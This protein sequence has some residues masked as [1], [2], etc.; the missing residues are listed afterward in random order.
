MGGRPSPELRRKRCKLRES[1]PGVPSAQTRYR[2]L[3]QG[4]DLVLHGAREDDWPRFA[5]NAMGRA[6]G[7]RGPTA[8]AV[9]SR[10]RRSR[11]RSSTRGLRARRYS[12]RRSRTGSV[13]ARSAALRAWRRR[14]SPG[15]P[16][17]CVSAARASVAARVRRRRAPPRRGA[18]PRRPVA[19]H[20]RDAR[21]ERWAGEGDRRVLPAPA[22]PGACVDIDADCAVH[23][24]AARSG[25]LIRRARPCSIGR[26]EVR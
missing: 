23:G 22:S 18:K 14:H 20:G 6:V 17:R 10:R 8:G 5:S 7:R 4:V 21:C 2:R 9:R 13:R 11:P 24:P 3:Y 26:N 25:A 16:Q 15:L 19:H 1:D 12:M